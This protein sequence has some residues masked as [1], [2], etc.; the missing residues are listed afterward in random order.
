[1]MNADPEKPG[2]KHIVFHPQPVADLS[3]VKYYNQTVYGEAGIEWKKENGTFLAKISVP[4]GCKAT[5]Y[6]PLMQGKVITESGRSIV[7]SKDL[8]SL[9][10]AEGYQVF[11]VKSGKYEF[12][13]K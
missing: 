1:G 13:S 4:V 11:A 5:V 8:K 7:N 10:E 9:K 3:F 2:Y 12:V 6:I